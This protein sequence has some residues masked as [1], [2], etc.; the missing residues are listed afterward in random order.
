MLIV[1]LTSLLWCL[2][3]I[4]EVRVMTAEC[5]W[6]ENLQHLHLSWLHTEIST[7]PGISTEINIQNLTGTWFLSQYTECLLIFAPSL[8]LNALSLWPVC[9]PLFT[10]RVAHRHERETVQSCLPHHPYTLYDCSPSPSLF[11][12]L[13]TTSLSLSLTQLWLRL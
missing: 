1:Y 12:F 11:I 3:L 9:L 2:S 4:T 7:D 10:C 13:I 5:D 6:A 8:A